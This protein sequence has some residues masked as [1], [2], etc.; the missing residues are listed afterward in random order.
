M[1]PKHCLNAI[2]GGMATVLMVDDDADV[3]ATLAAIVKSAGHRVVQASSG[4]TA[5]D[6]LD[7][8]LSIDLMVTDVIMPGLNG[9]NLAQMARLR[10]HSLRVLYLSG[11]CD[12]V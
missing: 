5:L 9:F 12:T 11:Y 2:G 3:L 8:D 1:I 6:I 10:R 7:R 4:I